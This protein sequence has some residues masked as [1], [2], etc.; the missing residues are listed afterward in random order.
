MNEPIPFLLADGWRE[1]PDQFRQYARCFFKQ[2]ETPT[3]CAGN[4]DKAGMQVQIAVS[5]DSAHLEMEIVGGLSDGSWIKLHQYA[6]GQ[7]VEKALA[8][9]PRLLA[10]WE[11]V[12]T[13][14][15][16]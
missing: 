9:I 4:D 3:R 14:E 1:H 7:D 12:A 10:A 2:L 13:Y 6:M 5:R 16:E 15:R 8:G 11:R